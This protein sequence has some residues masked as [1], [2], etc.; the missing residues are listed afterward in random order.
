MGGKKDEF[1]GI[2]G[3]PKSACT[4]TQRNLPFCSLLSFQAG[5]TIILSVD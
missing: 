3:T 1:G 5:H 4:M 2:A